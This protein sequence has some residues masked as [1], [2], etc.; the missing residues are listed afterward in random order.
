[1]V[2]V[3]PDDTVIR[4]IVLIVENKRKTI[5]VLDAKRYLLGVVAGHSL[6][7]T[8]MRAHASRRKET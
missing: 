5:P 3:R 4:A 1:M 6:I 8:V 2:D 7:R